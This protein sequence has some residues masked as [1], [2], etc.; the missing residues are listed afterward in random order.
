MSHR[1]TP[2]RSLTQCSPSSLSWPSIRKRIYTT[3]GTVVRQNHAN[4]TG[5]I[6]G[7]KT[8]LENAQ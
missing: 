2:K 8:I 3:D 7:W 1:K 4:P 5:E 6:A